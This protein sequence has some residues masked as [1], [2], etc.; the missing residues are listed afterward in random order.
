ML[1]TFEIDT[2]T[3]AEREI[4]IDLSSTVEAK[5][6]GSVEPTNESLLLELVNFSLH[7]L[8]TFYVWD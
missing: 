8:H 4:G 5:G 1:A 7:F 2:T 6:Q 3:R